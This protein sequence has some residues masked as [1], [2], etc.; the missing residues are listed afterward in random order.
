[1]DLRGVRKVRTRMDRLRE[2]IEVL[3]SAKEYGERI[4]HN[5]GGSNPTAD[6]LPRIIARIEELTDEL[7]SCALDYDIEVVLAESVI[8]KLSE[9]EQKIARARYIDGLSWR[10]VAER[11]NYSVGRCRNVNTDIVRK[12]NGE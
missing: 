8:E 10:Q 9:S 1:M 11:T 4:A 7:V 12:V 5:G 2:H 3:N 6:K